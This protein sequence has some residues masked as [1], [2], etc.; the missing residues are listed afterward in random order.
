MPWCS[1]TSNQ[2]MICF[3]DRNLWP[4]TKKGSYV[5]QEL[6]N[7][8]IQN[9]FVRLNTVERNRGTIRYRSNFWIIP[10]TSIWNRSNFWIIHLTSIWNRNQMKR[11][12]LA[13]S[14]WH[15]VV[16][17]V[18]RMIWA[19]YITL[20]CPLRQVHSFVV[21]YYWTSGKIAG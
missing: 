14:S 1:S 2:T 21:V 4:A 7:H 12:C 15:G 19:L 20:T 8:R 5:F 9:I 6:Q 17:T 3:E 10:L 13:I 11:W 18:R 16:S